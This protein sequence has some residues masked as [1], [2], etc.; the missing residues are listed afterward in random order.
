MKKQLQKMKMLIAA[1]IVFALGSTNT[2]A[3]TS[4]VWT[5]STSTEFNNP[6]NWGGTVDF[7]GDLF[8]NYPNPNAPT[9]STSP[10]GKP[11]KLDIDWANL[12]VNADYSITTNYFIKGPVT[13]GAGATFSSDN[14]FFVGKYAASTL[15]VNGT[16]KCNGIVNYTR[17]F[18][19]CSEGSGTLAYVNNGG[20]IDGGQDL[21]IGTG[22]DYA[23]TALD[24][25][26]GGTAK[27]HWHTRIGPNA[28]INVKGGTLDAG[29]KLTVGEIAANYTETVPGTLPAIV[30]QLNINSGT[31]NVNNNGTN[32]TGDPIFLHSLA[33]VTIDAG[34][35]VISNLSSNYSSTLTLINGY[36]TN[37]QISAASGKT[38]SVVANGSSQ[39]TVTAEIVTPVSLISY[40]AEAKNNSALLKW[41][42]ASEQNN[43]HFVLSRS[44]D[45]VQ[46]NLLSTVEASKNGNVKN[47]YAYT[48]MNPSNGN[49]YYRL[50]QVDLD[51][52]VKELGIKVVNFS[53]AE[54]Q[55]VSV[56]PN[57][58][59]SEAKVNFESGVYSSAKLIDLQGRVR[60]KK[61]ISSEDTE[62]I[63]DIKSLDPGHYLIQL[64]GAKSIVQKLIKE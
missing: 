41:S 53:L 32:T 10:S 59:Q 29:N 55:S 36:V 62:V 6:L 20:T 44:T 50:A 17:L 56:Y 27:A 25:N 11:T 3:Q 61:S 19:G 43:S 60:Y 46:F 2:Y 23:T 64:D 33:K 45:G 34:S 1:S 4:Y 12:T 7:T 51:G 39:I 58:T 13:V 49:N 38:I 22:D 57:P 21:Q 52:T 42:T 30:G 37:G 26:A 8:L 16:L 24:I 31:V 15:V 28:T 35:L 48:D 63:F 40:T 54:N 18:I 14:T 47:N 5:G 9:I